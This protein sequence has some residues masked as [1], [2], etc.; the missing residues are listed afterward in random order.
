MNDSKLTKEINYNYTAR[1]NSINSDNSDILK[2]IRSL[3]I[4]KT[5]WHDDISL[6]MIKLCDQSLV[7]LLPLILM[8]RIESGVYP[9]I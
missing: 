3:N 1:V 9:D 7:K 2:S 5:C 6:R 4:N 8:G